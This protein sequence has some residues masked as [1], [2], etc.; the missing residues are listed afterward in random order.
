LRVSAE[1]CTEEV[2]VAGKARV[3]PKEFREDAVRLY[4][5]SGKPLATV[6]REL[7]IAIQSRRNSL[8]QDG[9]DT[10]RRTDGGTTEERDELG[11]L[12][13]ENRILID[14]ALS[15]PRPRGSQSSTG[16]RLGTN[17]P[18]RHSSLAMLAPLEF[19]RRW[20]NTAIS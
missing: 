12:R 6:S 5:S 3:Y 10:G 18:R 1:R 4:R 13:R 14:C 20:Q 9:L 16:W 2:H 11:H 17:R 8:K 15:R 19:E 7:G